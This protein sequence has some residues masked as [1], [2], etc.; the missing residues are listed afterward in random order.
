MG[1]G[2]NTLIGLITDITIFGMGLLLSVVLT[3]NLK[4]EGRTIYALLVTTNLILAHVTNLSVGPAF[5]TFLAQGR[6][7]LGMV[8]MIA[9]IL[10]F[11]LGIVVLIGMSAAFPLLRESIFLNVPYD[12]LL[13]ALLLVPL[14]IYQMYWNSM[15]VG[16][17]LP[18][19]L[20]RLNLAINLSNT[21]LM[22]L[23]IG[24]LQWGIAGFLGA[25]VIG[26]VAGTVAALITAM[27]MERFAR[28]SGAALRE[29]LPFALRLHGAGIA[30]H[31]FLRFDVYA[32]NALVRTETAVGFYSLATSLAEKLWVPLNALNVS[33]AGKVAQLSPQE[34]A[35]LTAKVIRTGLLLMLGLAVPFALISPQL[36]PFLYGAEFSMSVLPLIILL[37]GTPAFA[38]TLML[39][40]YIIGQMKKPGL[41]S[42]LSWFQLAISV[43]LYAGLTLW[44]G[45]VG[46]AL[47]STLSYLIAMSVALT[48]FVRDSGLPVRAVL[49]PRRT[50]F[51]DYARVLQ[52]GLRKV[53][54]L[55]RYARSPS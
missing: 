51:Q 7:R 29:M 1:I 6:Y 11:A 30:H 53:P 31:I 48:I 32:V 47:A 2:K 15:M 52:A 41:L 22:L 13:I 55:R 20:N 23:F 42:I 40:N 38:L 10:S 46:A 18:L 45:I 36:I 16:L 12:Y 3:Q 9:V 34:S 27:R 8:N 33:S 44:Q 25:W 50:D 54:I 49:V 14:T 39:N 28:P 24:V 5:T 43:P 35:L 37:A 21:L 17:N 19:V 26:N 4:A